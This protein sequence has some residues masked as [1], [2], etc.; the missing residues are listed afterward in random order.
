MSRESRAA[1]SIERGRDVRRTRREQRTR[2]GLPAHV[3][4]LLGDLYDDELSP[5]QKELKLI[6]RDLQGENASLW[7]SVSFVAGVRGQA[8]RSHTSRDLARLERLGHI[9]RW[10]CSAPCYCGQPPRTHIDVLDRGQ[11]AM[12]DRGEVAA[13]NE[14]QEN[15]NHQD[16]SLRSEPRASAR[17]GRDGKRVLPLHIGSYRENPLVGIEGDFGLSPDVMDEIDQM[18][19]NSG[20]PDAEIANTVNKRLREAA[21]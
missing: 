6:L 19:A 15:E 17:V 21:A 4:A 18:I 13:Q 1:T 14:N 20:A 16:S 3:K 5:A 10:R 11:V 7:S 2:E 12:R 9:R 8:D